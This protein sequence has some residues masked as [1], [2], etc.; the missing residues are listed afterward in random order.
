MLQPSLPKLSFISTFSLHLQ[1]FWWYEL[2]P[3]LVHAITPITKCKSNTSNF[4]L[5]QFYSCDPFSACGPQKF[6]SFSMVEN[7]QVEWSL[8]VS[9]KKILF[10]CIKMDKNQHS[11][12][13]R[14]IFGM[15]NN[16]MKLNFLSIYCQTSV[17]SFWI[18][19]DIKTLRLK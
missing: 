13:I 7:Y 8:Y 18:D 6:K 3:L 11:D 1:I 12:W 19:S 14:V 2:I 16:N 4:N 9:L 17:N 5:G 10:R 15:M